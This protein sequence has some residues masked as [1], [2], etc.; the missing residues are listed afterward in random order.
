MSIPARKPALVRGSAVYLFSNLT[1]AA[2]PFLLLPVLTRFLGPSEYGQ[3]AMF[4]TLVGALAALTGL[5]VASAANRK[6]YDRD[7]SKETIAHFVGACL[8]ILLASALLVF[9]ATWALLPW[10]GEQLGL[11][12]GWVLAAVLVACGNFV[13]QL[14]LGLWQASNDAHRYGM[15]QV[16][17]TAA[18]ML[19]SLWFVIT[20]SMGAGG[21][22][23]A[24]VLAAGVATV[25][26]VVL[27]RRELLL[28][29]TWQPK[30]VREALSFGVPLVPHVA[31]LFVL[32]AADRLVIN[33][34]LGLAEA[35]IYMVA[36]QVTMMLSLLFDAFNKAYVPWLFERL[37]DGAPAQKRAI[38]RWT[39]VHFAAASALAGLG[40]L[41]GPWAVDIFAGPAFR[42]AG[43]V[44]GWLAVGQAFAG[45][46]LMVT[47]YLFYEKRTGLLAL[48][49]LSSGAL[50]IA[51]LLA[52]V[53]IFGLRGAAWAF[54][55]AMAVR[56]LL[57]WAVA[58]KIHPMPW[59]NTHRNAHIAPRN[60]P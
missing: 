29:M 55:V 11:A 53:P 32:A 58:R 57:T 51:L 28:S 45:M 13:V 23:W 48:V 27:L 15:L 44:V 60:P 17:M 21:R 16:G 5:N 30:M 26:A 1:N 31:G 34:K 20:L 56:F 35:G 41:V 4:Q 43:E 7:A 47:N 36:V 40:V 10:L 22:I 39:Y 2:I 54:C 52:W 9:A 59:F 19:I 25:F 12:P 37:R 24:Q 46:Y 49:T 33:E 8:T 3:V 6:V 18:N 42:R 38:V 50:D 14:R